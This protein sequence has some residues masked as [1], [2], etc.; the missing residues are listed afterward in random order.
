MRFVELLHFLIALHRWEQTK[1][2][3]ILFKVGMYILLL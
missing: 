1:S 3:Q 2:K